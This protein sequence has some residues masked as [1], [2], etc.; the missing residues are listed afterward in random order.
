[1]TALVLAA[2]TTPP[3]SRLAG[4]FAENSKPVAYG[5]NIVNVILVDFRALDTFGEITVLGIAAFGVYA[6]LKLGR[7]QRHARA[8]DRRL[9]P[10][11]LRGVLRR[12]LQSRK[13][14]KA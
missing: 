6:L 7:R 13:G 12:G 9:R 3:V 4:F 5:N 2:T 14:T 1:M 8:D 10:T 11:G